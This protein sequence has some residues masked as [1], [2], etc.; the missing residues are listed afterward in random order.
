ML[1]L[2]LL[3]MFLRKARRVPNYLH[4]FVESPVDF[5]TAKWGEFLVAR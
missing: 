5:D 1:R 3:L 4:Q 2:T